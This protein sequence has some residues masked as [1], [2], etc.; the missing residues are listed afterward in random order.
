VPT[1]GRRF[2]AEQHAK[3]LSLIAANVEREKIATQVGCSTES[4]RRWYNEAK[5]KGLVA[6]PGKEHGA[7]KSST[8]ATPTTSATPGASATPTTS[9]SSAPLDP[10][11][12]LGEHEVKAILDYKK[13]HPSMGPAQIRAQLKRFLG[14][15]VSVKAIARVLRRAGFPAVHRKGRPVGQER[16]G[17]FE[18][19]HRNALWQLDF[20][21]LRIGPCESDRGVDTSAPVMTTNASYTV[22]AWA[23]L[24]DTLMQHTIVS[25]S[26]TNHSPF[27]LQ[28]DPGTNKWRLYISS[29]DVS[30][31]TWYNAAS[32]TIT[33]Q[34]GVDTPGRRVRLGCQDRQAVHQRPGPGQ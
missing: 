16:P 31:P 34:V 7:A 26:G 27:Y 5:R 3:A 2:S 29:A 18:A 17:R 20:T 32:T 6:A 33:P 21:E 28:Y 14:W 12:G 22:S 11:A 10:G 24:T 9:A 23:R 30:A 1:R 25:Q 4:L 13:K 19:P 15:R 8:P